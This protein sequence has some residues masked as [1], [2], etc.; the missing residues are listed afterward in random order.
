MK[1]LTKFLLFASAFAFVIYSCTK[2]SSS[3][4]NLN[5]TDEEVAPVITYSSGEP[6]EG[7]YIVIFKENAFP[8]LQ[9]RTSINKENYQLQKTELET[10]T[11]S[12]LRDYGLATK[13]LKQ[14]YVKTVTGVAL[15]LT[16]EEVET[17]RRDERVDY[18][19]QDQVIR[20]SMDI[21]VCQVN[22]S[23]FE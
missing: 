10:Q 14:S 13:E 19:E 8:T 3:I 21:K 16:E 23:Q 6:I 1:N 11:K 12:M 9:G 22:S 18:I 2:E 5:L 7:S 17:L 4:E 20:V 15:E